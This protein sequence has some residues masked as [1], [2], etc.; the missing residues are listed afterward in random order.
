MI[1]VNP[2]PH[3]ENEKRYQHREFT[4]IEIEQQT[5]ALILDLSPY[6]AL[7]HPEHVNGGQNHANSGNNGICSIDSESTQ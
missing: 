6:N 7:I 5:I 3:H 1:G 2:H 4:A